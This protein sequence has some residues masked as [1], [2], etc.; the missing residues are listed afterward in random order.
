MSPVA[1]RESLVLD[2]LHRHDSLTIE[3]I[4]AMLPELSWS[5][6]FQTVDAL[7][8]KGAICLRRKGFGY[9]LRARPQQG[10]ELYDFAV[11]SAR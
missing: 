10:I 11:K 1:T 8:R 7:S 2:M 6:L 3:E 9:E 5:E 4:T